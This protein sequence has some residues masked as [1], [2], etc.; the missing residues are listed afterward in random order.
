MC[1]LMVGDETIAL[2]WSETLFLW[3]TKVYC[4]Q[5]TRSGYASTLLRYH[6]SA[7]MCQTVRVG[8]SECGSPQLSRMT[9]RKKGKEKKEEAGW[10][11]ATVLAVCAQFE[12]DVPAEQSHLKDLKHLFFGGFLPLIHSFGQ[13]E[14][15]TRCHL[16]PSIQ[17]KCT[18]C[19]FSFF[20]NFDRLW[21][22]VD[23]MWDDVQH[24]LV[25]IRFK[26]CH[27]WESRESL[28]H[29]VHWQSSAVTLVQRK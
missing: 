14:E 27:L 22:A 28:P 5:V 16:W 24:I 1:V 2:R 7:V 29:D 18:L 17:R 6:A 25:I 9:H 20:I 12:S 19:V 13:Q 26:P 8:H 23:Q 10:E 4:Q 3:V 21:L 11:T 15:F